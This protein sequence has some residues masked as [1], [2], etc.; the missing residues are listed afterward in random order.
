MQGQGLR[1]SAQDFAAR[2]TTVIGMSFDSPTENRAFARA[3]HFP[4]H[5][6]SDGDHAVGQAY[7]VVRPAADQYRNF[8]RRISYLIDPDGVIRAVYDIADVA[9]HASEVLRDLAEL[10]APEQQ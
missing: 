2:H 4:F 9:G 5:L 8:P 3:Q 7:G 6:L 1:D 10:Q